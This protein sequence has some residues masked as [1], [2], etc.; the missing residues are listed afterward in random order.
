MPVLREN[1]APRFYLPNKRASVSY[2]I[3]MQPDLDAECVELA[4][5]PG[6]ITFGHAQIRPHH[7]HEF[8]LL[9]VSRKL[10]DFCALF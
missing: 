3:C 5:I 1:T 2:D 4:F 8:A 6:L 7:E 9:V 10:F